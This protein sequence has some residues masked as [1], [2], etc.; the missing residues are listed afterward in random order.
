MES[1]TRERELFWGMRAIL[2]AGGGFVFL[3]GV[4]LFGLA[5]RTDELFAWTIE[6]PATA[7]FLGAC[8]WAAA[9]LAFASALQPT[10]ARARIGVAGVLVFIWLTLLATL[11]H[12]DKFHLDDGGTRAQIAGWTWLVIYLLEPPA[13]LAAYVVQLRIPGTDPP[14]DRP[15]PRGLRGALLV[16]AFLFTAFGAA[17][18]VAPLDVG[19][20]WPWPLTPLTG[21]ATAAW[22]VALGLLLASMAWEDDRLRLLPGWALLATLVPLA[23]AA[24]LRFDEG[25]DWGS[26]EMVAYLALGVV[27]FALA[28]YGLLRSRS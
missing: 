26:P 22:I 7:A 2:W 13:L 20:L 3:A 10:W 16:L 6:P 25:V 23:V 4:Q 14:R 17:L 28:G 11:I 27:L 15:L 19:D 24:P 9:V 8:Y 12:L 5:D 21:R 1:G 18:Y